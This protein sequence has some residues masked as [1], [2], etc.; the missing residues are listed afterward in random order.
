MVAFVQAG[1]NDVAALYQPHR[2]ARGMPEPIMQNLLYPRAGGIDERARPQRFAGGELDAPE[3]SLALRAP[4]FGLHEDARAPRGRV[5]R[6]CD[7]Q[8]GVV[9]AAVGID[10]AMPELG[11]QAG[12]VRRAV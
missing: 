1:K 3:C 10:K 7:H 9:D 8:P 2:I 12:T 4:A 5:E 6:V 11:A